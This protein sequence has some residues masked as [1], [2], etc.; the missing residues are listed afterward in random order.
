MDGIQ[1]PQGL[2]HF[3]EAVYFL[4]LSSQNK[5]IKIK[6]F[7]HWSLAY[8]ITFFSV[9]L[10]VVIFMVWEDSQTLVSKIKQTN[11]KISIRN[12]VEKVENNFKTRDL[13]IFRCK[14]NLVLL[15]FLQLEFTKYRTF[16]PLLNLELH[17]KINLPED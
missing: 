14:L 2:S 4:P 13:R 15:I 3:E 6:C 8:H 1:L 16:H 7:K 11:L 5:Y 9:L 17:E 10:H 12:Y